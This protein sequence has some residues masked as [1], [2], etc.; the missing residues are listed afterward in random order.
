M[1]CR[2]YNKSKGS[3]RAANF[4]SAVAR[5]L[6]ILLIGFLLGTCGYLQ[7]ATAQLPLLEA[8]SQRHP[9]W[10]EYRASVPVGGGFRV[11][12]MTFT[13]QQ[14]VNPRQFHV[15][16]PRPNSAENSLLCVAI[17]SKDGR[18]EAELA[19]RLDQVKY[20]SS[21]IVQPVELPTA[22]TS[23]LRAYA[24]VDLA[25]LAHISSS[26]DSPTGPSGD[27]V[28]A[29][30][31]HDGIKVPPDTISVLINSDVYASVVGGKE[32]AID[33]ETP[34][35]RLRG[36]NK[37][38]NRRCDIPVDR[39]APGVT[40]DVRRRSSVGTDDYKYYSLPLRLQ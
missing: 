33:F 25:I 40:L 29:S 11:G 21:L 15:F 31:N 9:G 6:T 7:E 38:Y 8:P 24:P 16:L 34:C 5:I 4:S 1:T 27:Y 30:W 10:E 36:P 17:S 32:F 28:V 23:K 18:Y 39:L 2:T 22:H 13:E 26:C 37:A 12:L 14:T 35:Q 3:L 19:Y 20:E